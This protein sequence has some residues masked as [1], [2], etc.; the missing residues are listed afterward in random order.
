MYIYIYMASVN[1]S[2]KEEAYERL[3]SIKRPDESFSDEILRIT[4]KKTG[5][6]LKEA[7]GLLRDSVS[8]ED[9]RE[10]KKS[11]KNIRGKTSYIQKK[12]GS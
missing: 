6:G 9:S 8:A 7:F 12:W 3:V 10:M 2:L 11:I 5:E 1:I 4:G